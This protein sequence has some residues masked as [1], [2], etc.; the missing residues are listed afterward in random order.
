[1]A[2]RSKSR[3]RRNKNKKEPLSKIN[4]VKSTNQ[5]SSRDKRARKKQLERQRKFRRRRIGL[6]IIL[7][8]L[9][10]FIGKIIS[11]AVNTYKVPGYPD[12]RDE[13]LESI[14][15]EVFV[16]NSEGRSLS[17]AEKVTDFDDLYKTV[18]RNFAVDKDNKENFQTFLS[19]YDDFRKKVYK[20]KTDQDYFNLINQYLEIL[21]D[22]RSF[23]L[24]KETYDS[25][26]EYYRNTND[27]YKKKVLENPQAVNRYKRLIGSSNGLNVAMEAKVLNGYILNI[28]LSDF[29]ANEF[30]KDLKKIVDIL[31]SN[32][33]LTTVILDLSNNKSIDAYY[34]NKLLEILLHDNY[35]KSNTIF[36]RGNLMADELASIKANESSNYKTANLANKADNYKESLTLIDP[37]DYMAYD[38]VSV[39]IKKDQ[40]YSNRNIY[41][42][43]N[44]NTCNEAIR[45]ASILKS[46][47]AYIVKND[48]DSKRSKNDIIYN[49]PTNL[50]TLEHS[51]LVVS[52]NGSYSKNEE[53]TY[54]TY[55]QRINSKDPISSMLGIIN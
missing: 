35:E 42:L 53:D 18:E 17:T 14:G 2:K 45:L 55:D 44:S 22:N 41:V 7:I 1:M 29:R 51:G 23:V 48:F 21:D 50:Y 19:S 13:V 12:F 39:N 40:D 27:S 11:K 5:V 24:E 25:L 8:L 43:V 33:P 10:I 30:D 15:N 49:M 47:G 32:P 34:A 3:Q 38:E 36:Y 31:L 46:Q 52:I 16:S 26:F 37:K 54:L 4:V 28:T 20:S 6:L 9:V